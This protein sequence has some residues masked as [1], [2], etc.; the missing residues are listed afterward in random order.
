MLG[1]LKNWNLL[2]LLLGSLAFLCIYSTG[3]KHQNSCAA[4]LVVTISSQ[5]KLYARLFDRMKLFLGLCPMTCKVRNC[6]VEAAFKAALP[7]LKIRHSLSCNNV[8]KM[9]IMYT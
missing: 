9:I 4:I 8:N 2:L 7:L 6:Q 5:F 3:I 1:T